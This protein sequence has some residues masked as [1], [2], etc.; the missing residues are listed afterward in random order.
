MI[1]SGLPSHFTECQ[2]QILSRGWPWLLPKVMETE[3][4]SAAAGSCVG[5]KPTG[6]SS[7]QGSL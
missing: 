4:G 2:E 1:V 3:S 6:L 5:L 7:A